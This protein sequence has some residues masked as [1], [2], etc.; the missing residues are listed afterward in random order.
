MGSAASLPFNLTRAAEMGPTYPVAINASSSGSNIVVA[1]V[2][3]KR[4]VVLKYKRIASAAVTATWQSSGGV[5]LDGPCALPANGGEVETTVAPGHF[6]TYPGESLV[7]FL[8]SAV[9]VGGNLHYTLI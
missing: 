2:T 8:N 7:L 5:V 4:I 9:Q 6:S 3:G 1:G